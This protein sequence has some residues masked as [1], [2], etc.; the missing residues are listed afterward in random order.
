MRLTL[1]WPEEISALSPV[2]IEAELDPPP[3]VRA[4]AM[5]SATVLDPAIATYGVFGL[6]RQDGNRYVAQEPLRLPL[7]PLGGYWWLLVHVESTLEVAGDKAL[8][9][10]PTPI[11][12]RELT[13]ALPGGVTMRVPV[14]FT[15][16]ITQGDQAAGGRVWRFCTMALPGLCREEGE[17]A[18]WWAPGPAEPLLLNT[19]IVMLETTHDPDK[20]PRL[21][22]VEETLWE[23]QTAFLFREDWR[24]D[25]GGPAEA[26]VIQGP[27]RWLYVLRARVIGGRE[28]PA[29]LREVAETFRLAS[30]SSG[31]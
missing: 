9:F 20:P 6:A 8:A 3:G 31:R 11:R 28:I 29:L 5:I 24:G 2:F 22:D 19:A 4:S 23:G 15:E 25:Q 13:N 17:V 7:E 21:Q 10:R 26:W 16:V 14:A 12:F 1:H 27:D 18:L 30:E